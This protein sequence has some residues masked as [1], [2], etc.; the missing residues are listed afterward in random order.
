MKKFFFLAVV[1]AVGSGIYATAALAQ[2]EAGLLYLMIKPGARAAGSGEAFVATADDALA[3]YYNPAGLA[4]QSDKVLSM[5]HT[6]WLP[7]FA[8]DLYHEFFAYAWHKE[9]WGNFGIHVIYMS[10]GEQVRVDEIGQVRGTYLPFDAALGV[11]YG[12][13]LSDGS[14]AG[15]T[16]KIMYSRLSPEGT[17]AEKGSG[18]S[19][20]YAV[21]LG[22]LRKSFLFRRLSLGVT[23]QNV[24]P[25]ISY[26][27]TEQSDPL[28]Q[29]LKVGFAYQIL[30]SE[31]N[32]LKVS[33]DFSKLL[34]RR[35]GGKA[36]PFYTAL[37]TSWT[38]KKLKTEID[39][40]ITNVGL[41]Y[42]YNSWLSLRAGCIRDTYF[43]KGTPFMTFG[44]GLRYSLFQFDM[45]YMPMPETPLANNTRFSLT[46][47]L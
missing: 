27:D 26:I 40:V 19:T 46:V 20:S 44:G 12:A 35:T 15:V 30:Q 25:S 24:G 21:D 22:Y 29:N 31:Y 3:T 18:T 33:A 9:G 1:L 45:A 34:V 7:A 16:M 23:L 10:Y 13:R 42:W 41:E 43:G 36:D 17:G 8:N 39:E 47:R 32:S 38:D 2:S 4:F 37:L 14:S 28:P 5:S 6:N 11:S